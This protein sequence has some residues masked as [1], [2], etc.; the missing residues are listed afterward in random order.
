MTTDLQTPGYATPAAVPLE[1]RASGWVRFGAQ[2]LNAV[3]MVVTLVI[4]W[5]VWAMITWSR[6]SANP[7]QKIIGLKVVKKDTGQPLTW[8]ELFIRN[9]LLGYLVYGVTCGVLVVVDIFKSFGTERQRVLD[10]MA[11]TVVVRTK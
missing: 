3:L 1:Y 5:L 6:D 7:G 9:F 11:G 4:G 10:N 2:L 8:G